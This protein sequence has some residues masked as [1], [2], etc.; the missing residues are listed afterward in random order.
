M[1]WIILTGIACLLGATPAAARDLVLIGSKF[2]KDARAA[3][4]IDA[5]SVKVFGSNRRG[6]MYNGFSYNNRT[7]LTST[8]LVEFDCEGEQMRVVQTDFFKLDGSYDSKGD[9]SPWSFPPPQTNNYAT[10]QFACGKISV[11]DANH[12]GDRD[13]FDLFQRFFAQK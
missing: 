8:Q 9:S 7:P 11:P 10:L 6:W 2:E 13:P 3:M 4:F 12:F 5:D 1:K